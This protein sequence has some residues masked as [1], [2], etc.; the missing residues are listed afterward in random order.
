[1]KTE[2]LAKTVDIVITGLVVSPGD[3]TKSSLL[4]KTG[5]GDKIKVVVSLTS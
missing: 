3:N 5:V 1:M 2:V 4:V